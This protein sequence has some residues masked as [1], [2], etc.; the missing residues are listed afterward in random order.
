MINDH[1]YIS[2]SESILNIHYS[3]P[4]FHLVLICHCVFPRDLGG[5]L[6][7]HMT[8]TTCN[9]I[10]ANG[11]STHCLV[12][13][14]S[15]LSLNCGRQTI[16]NICNA[17]SHCIHCNITRSLKQYLFFAVFFSGTCLCR[18]I[19][20][21]YCMMEYD[22]RFKRLIMTGSWQISVL[23]VICHQLKITLKIS[24]TKSVFNIYCS[25]C[26]IN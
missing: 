16:Q 25:R 20:R 22:R 14:L 23:G 10:T 18:F 21:S 19:D 26:V 24:E 7:Y 13:L 2:T 9:E 11:T 4:A 3:L 6:L 5:R 12:N 1:H 17:G 8:C 15:F